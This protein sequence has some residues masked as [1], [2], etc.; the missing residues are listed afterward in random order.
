MITISRPGEWDHLVPATRGISHRS[1]TSSRL[2]GKSIEGSV[3]Y[4]L[5]RIIPCED[6]GGMR[7][8]SPYPH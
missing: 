8:A 2:P 5:A 7:R 1:T 4:D 6:C 3:N